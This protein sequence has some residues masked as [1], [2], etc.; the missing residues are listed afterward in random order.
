MTRSITSSRRQTGG[1]TRRRVPVE[2]V[3]VSARPTDTG[4]VLY[5][6]LDFVHTPLKL[7]LF[8]T[9]FG[10]WSPFKVELQFYISGIELS[11]K[12]SDITNASLR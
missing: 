3:T 4:H 10:F 5:A 6:Q 2:D 1:T 11:K 9:A 12:I 7:V 8:A